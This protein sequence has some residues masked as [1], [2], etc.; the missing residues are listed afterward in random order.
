MICYIA[1]MRSY[2]GM[3]KK[4][5]TIKCTTKIG[6]YLLCVCCKFLVISYLCV[7]LSLWLY[8]LVYY[9]V[10]SHLG[11]RSNRNYYLRLILFSLYDIFFAL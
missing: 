5:Y 9:L 6:L 2:F 7:L 10:N 3:K 4:I 1:N 11:M 8:D